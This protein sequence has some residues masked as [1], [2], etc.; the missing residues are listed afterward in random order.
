MGVR[1]ND[2]RRKRKESTHR[3]KKGVRTLLVVLEGLVLGVGLFLGLL[4]L[5]NALAGGGALLLTARQ[6]R[7][8]PEDK[9]HDAREEDADN[10]G[11]HQQTCHATLT[12]LL[13][14]HPRISEAARRDHLC[15][16]HVDERH[17][18]DEDGSDESAKGGH[19]L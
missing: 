11:H 18:H 2:K 17:G 10:A 14:T 9:A 13:I 1:R 4:A 3:K 19:V 7:R 16:D 15:L 6:L 8:W 5:A 12:A